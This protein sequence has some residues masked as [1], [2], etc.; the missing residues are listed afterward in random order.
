MLVYFFRLTFHNPLH[1]FISLQL[2]CDVC[3]FSLFFPPGLLNISERERW[4]TRLLAGAKVRHGQW[5]EG[6][7][8]HCAVSQPVPA[9]QLLT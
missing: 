8:V 3:F 4:T 2:S 7:P 6:P 5:P 9:H 1:V